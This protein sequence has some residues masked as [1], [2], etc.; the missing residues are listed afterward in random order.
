M[1]ARELV[2]GAISLAGGS[3][4]GRVRLQKVMYL[5]TKKGLGGPFRFSYHHYGPF[6]RDVDEAISDAKA[7]CGLREATRHRELDGAPFSVFELPATAAHQLPSSFGNLVV[8]QARADIACMNAVTSTVIEVAATIFWLKHEERVPDW[9]V[10]LIR[11]KGAKAGSGRIDE[12][13]ALLVE[14]GLESGPAMA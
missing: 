8:E 10:E 4:I 7:F 5:L 3:V 1:S 13:L 12:A 6:S 2:A 14:L 9:R 11:R